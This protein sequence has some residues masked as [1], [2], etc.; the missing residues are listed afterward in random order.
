MLDNRNEA[1]TQGRLTVGKVM[2][3]PL[4]KLYPVIHNLNNFNS[5]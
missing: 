4:P 5:Y 1:Q 3:C 2:W